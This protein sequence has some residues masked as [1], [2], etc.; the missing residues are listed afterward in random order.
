MAI[1]SATTILSD[2]QFQE[3]MRLAAASAVHALEPTMTAYNRR[4]NDL[5]EAN[6][7]YLQDGR[8]WRIVEKL[9][10]SEGNSVE[11]LCDNPDFNGQ[12]N[13]AVV[14]SGDWT[15][16]QPARFTGDSIDEALGAAVVAFNKWERENGSR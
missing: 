10:A 5:L 2:E 3:A 4:L 14:C 6:N 11:V 12:P 1:F 15:D 8:N 13:S 16:W 9:R 7:R